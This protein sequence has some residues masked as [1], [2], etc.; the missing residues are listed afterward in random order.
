MANKSFVAKALK[1]LRIWIIKNT[2][3][4]ALPFILV[5]VVV[6]MT[7][8]TSGRFLSL[9]NIGALASQLPELGLLSLA[10]VV[11][12]LTAGINLSIISS[13]NLVSV[14]MAIIMT[15]FIPTGSPTGTVL[16][17]LLITFA[18]GV[19]VSLLLGF[20]N[21]FLIAYVGLPAMLATLGTMFLYEGLT[22][23]ITKGFVISG[24]PELYTGLSS[25][26][27][28]GVPLPLVILILGIAGVAL[29]LGKTPFG[30]YLFLIG[31]SETATRFS[32]V[33]TRKALV[34]AYVLSGLLCGIAGMVM[35][36]RFN[37]ANARSGSSLLL[38]TILIA[39]LGG[40]DP[41]GGFGKISGLVLS[42]LTLQF[43]TSG[44]NLLGITQF[45]TLA[46]WG[47]LLILV[48]AYRYYMTRERRAA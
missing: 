15:H 8:A 42:L 23:A 24:L 9:G 19:A 27:I 30:K 37:S 1:A 20:V 45:V 44:L 2:D 12:I 11:V 34:Q 38:L 47:I 32:A 43:I 7:V 40:T 22:L 10:M 48:I 18:V 41:N 5:A 14:L 36:S 6:F 25:A 21:G 33:D 31:S 16:V 46:L 17:G 3:I 4:A 26:A 29:I 39:V 13:A 28:L 35:L